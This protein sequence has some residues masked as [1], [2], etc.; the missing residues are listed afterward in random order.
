MTKKHS[1]YKSEREDQSN[2][3]ETNVAFTKVRADRERERERCSS[4]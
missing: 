2:N 4:A 1:L 3:K